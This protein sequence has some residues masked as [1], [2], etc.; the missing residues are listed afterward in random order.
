MN[1][2]LDPWRD[3]DGQADAAAMVASLEARGRTAAQVRLRRRFL[4][5]IPV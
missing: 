3:V 1:D 5:F 4:R 2:R